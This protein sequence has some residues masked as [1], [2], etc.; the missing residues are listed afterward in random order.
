MKTDARVTYTRKIIRETFIELLR[1]QPINKITVKKICESAQINRTTFYKHF[2]D[3]YDLMQNIEDETIEELFHLIDESNDK[4]FEQTMF[5]I[6]NAVQENK[7]FYQTVFYNQDAHGFNE[8]LILLCYQA[9]QPEINRKLFLSTIKEQEWFYYFMTQGLCSILDCW[10][11]DG[12]NDNTQMISRFLGKMHVI[13]TK[14][15]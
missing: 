7:A 11:K 13:L 15:G 3:P 5:V 6:L 9:K 8:K 2:A 12:M 10:I 14:D 1:K 4:S